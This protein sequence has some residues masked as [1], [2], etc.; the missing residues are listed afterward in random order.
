MGRVPAVWLLTLAIVFPDS[1]S[2]Q[3]GRRFSVATG[4]AIGIDDT[5]PN[6]GVHLRASAA[7]AP[8]PRTLNLL[9]DGYVTW[10]APATVER[11][12]VFEPPF[13]VRERETQAGIGLSG[14]LSFLP[15]SSVCPY[16]LV[17]AVSRWSDAN[18]RLTVRDDSGQV[19]SQISQDQTEHQFDILLGL[20]TAI[21]WGARRLL[22]EA[23]LYGG[24]AITMPITIGLTL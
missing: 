20:G 15:R 3:W 13:S 16:L 14:L 18:A 6:A 1:T 2:A 23:R 21:R 22:L 12:G 19:I 11:G 4:P 9:A 17:G 24:T 5:P 8:G 7:V 10:L